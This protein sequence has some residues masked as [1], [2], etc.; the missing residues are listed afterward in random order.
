MKAEISQ[1][2]IL[3]IDDCNYISELL[4]EIIK[5]KGYSCKAVNNF[6]NVMKELNSYK[7]KLIFL[8]VNMP[9]LNGYKFCEM[10][11]SEKKFQNIL[12][13]YLTGVPESEVFIK[14]LETH[15][16]GFIT[17]PFDIHDFDDVFDYLSDD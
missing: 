11:K 13:Y 8:D 2:D 7:P 3:I 12:V 4:T 15:A 1:Y 10:I 14:A 16:D 5:S 6:P 9:D 17:K